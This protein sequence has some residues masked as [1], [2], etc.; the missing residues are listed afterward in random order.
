MAGD[1]SRH[2][3]AL[4]DQN[5]TICNVHWRIFGFDGWKALSILA[6]L[7]RGGDVGH[8]GFDYVAGSMDA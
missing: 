3:S 5:C 6:R 7:S 1:A 4:D 2:Y 8:T